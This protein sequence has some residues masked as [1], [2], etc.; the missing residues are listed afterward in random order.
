MKIIIAKYGTENKTSFPACSSSISDKQNALFR[1]ADTC[2]KSKGT[3]VNKS[4][5][6]CANKQTAKRAI[7]VIFFFLRQEKKL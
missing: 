1:T 5:Y 3:G 4:L 6:C 7:L 2:K